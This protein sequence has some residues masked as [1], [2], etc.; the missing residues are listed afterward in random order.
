MSRTMIAMVALLVAGCGAPEPQ[1]A[2]APAP[3]QAPAPA[4]APPPPAPEPATP[5]TYGDD[6]RLDRLWDR[7]SDDDLDACDT[8]YWDSPLGS[9]YERY[10]MERQDELDVGMTDQDIADAF[11]AEFFLDIVWGDMGTQE[12]AEL[13][14]A[15]GVLGP[16]LSAQLVSDGMD[17][18]FGPE[19]IRPWLQAKC[20]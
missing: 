11:G 5:D 18:L 12:R 4:P 20:G 14:V 16:Q 7:C 19:D 15:Y 10:A 13:C 6:P 1:V 2:P 17:G 9:D 3:V 8:L